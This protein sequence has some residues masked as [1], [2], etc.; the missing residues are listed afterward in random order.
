MSLLSFHHQLEVTSVECLN[1][2]SLRLTT[3][4]KNALANSSKRYVCS[5]LAH[6]SRE[7]VGLGYVIKLNNEAVAVIEISLVDH[8]FPTNSI[9]CAKM[10]IQ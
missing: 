7:I 4:F 9:P 5:T 8:T 1:L 2:G 6:L 3:E 10:R